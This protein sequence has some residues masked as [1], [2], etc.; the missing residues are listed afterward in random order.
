MNYIFTSD[1]KD[2]YHVKY[3]KF[4]LAN[5]LKKTTIYAIICSCNKLKN[6]NILALH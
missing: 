2:V 1:L 5:R 6:S 3:L 4:R